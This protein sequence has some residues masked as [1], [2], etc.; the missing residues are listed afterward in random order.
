MIDDKT[1]THHYSDLK[2]QKRLYHVK[3]RSSQS[4]NKHE[5]PFPDKSLTRNVYVKVTTNAISL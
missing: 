3:I 2:N 4:C 5:A 1:H